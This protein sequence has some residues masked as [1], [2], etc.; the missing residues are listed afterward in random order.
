MKRAE[1][2]ITCQRAVSID[3]L[4]PVHDD[5]FTRLLLA[6]ALIERIT[7]LASDIRLAPYS[8]PLRTV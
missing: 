2:P 4:P 8:G 7:S 1:L 6:Q 3:G 5:P